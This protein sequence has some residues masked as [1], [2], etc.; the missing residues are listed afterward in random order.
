MTLARS[1]SIVLAFSSAIAAC[2]VTVRPQEVQQISSDPSSIE[3]V[4]TFNAPVETVWRA[5]TEPSDLTRWFAL[6]ANVE[7]RVGGAYELFWDSEH[8]WSNSTLGC[9]LTE[10]EPLRKIAL[11]WLGPDLFAD[12]MNKGD[13]PPTHVTIEFKSKGAATEVRIIHV[14]WGPGRH[15]QDAREYQIGF[16]RKAIADLRAFLQVHLGGPLAPARGSSSESP[17]E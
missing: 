9:K 2:V 5:F 12:I 14:G 7:L 4:Q 1:L 11:P 3:F 17:T 16:W 15:W 8:P 13:P 6:G 10:V